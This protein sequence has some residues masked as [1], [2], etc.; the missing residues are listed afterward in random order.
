[1]DRSRRN[2]IAYGII[3]SW[4]FF[5]IVCLL[6]ATV[7]SAACGCPIGANSPAPCVVFGL[8]IVK[9][10]YTLRVM[11]W[12]SIV[13]LPTGAIAW[14]AYFAYCLIERSIVRNRRP[15]TS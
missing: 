3:V 6:I 7:V 10:L 4:A 9:T 15:P 1:M 2:G 12:L 14:L 11:G 8:D 5:P 13:T